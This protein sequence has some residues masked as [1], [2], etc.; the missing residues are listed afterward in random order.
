MAAHL[1]P[2]PP[3]APLLSCSSS[4]PL[5]SLPSTASKLSWGSASASGLSSGR[6][7][8]GT[9]PKAGWLSL[10]CRSPA[11][12]DSSWHRLAH[13]LRSSGERVARL[14]A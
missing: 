13:A 12:R 9:L 5:I 4:L 1:A 3:H 8:C 10:S 6:S 14:A 11:R 2:S 7:R